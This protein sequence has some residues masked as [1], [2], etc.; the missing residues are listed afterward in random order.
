MDIHCWNV[1]GHGISWLL[2]LEKQKEP[3]VISLI[4]TVMT[5]FSNYPTELDVLTARDISAAFVTNRLLFL[6]FSFF[7]S[8]F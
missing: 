4:N 7:I 8:I 2:R 6:G 3:S 5:H 1:L